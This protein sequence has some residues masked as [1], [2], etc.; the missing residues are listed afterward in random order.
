MIEIFNQYNE[1][2]RENPKNHFPAV[3]FQEGEKFAQNEAGERYD[4]PAWND[5]DEIDAEKDRIA[6]SLK[7]KLD[8]ESAV[9]YMSHG[10]N[11]FSIGIEARANIASMDR[12]LD[13][14][15]ESFPVTYNT[16]DWRNPEV[17]FAD[18]NE[19]K[20]FTDA[21]YLHIKPK[22]QSVADLLK[23]LKNVSDWSGL[24]TFRETN[25]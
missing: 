18:A 20:A 12:K 13:Q 19:W 15:T 25:L 23:E 7:K 16:M 22:Y 10:D 21:M 9:E 14:G 3:V 8:D 5:A 24:R 6:Y 11:V 4:N 2:T 1:K 17:I